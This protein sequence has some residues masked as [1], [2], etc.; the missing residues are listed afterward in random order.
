MPRLRRRGLA[1]MGPCRPD[2]P[3]CCCRGD[4]V[5][6][7]PHALPGGSGDDPAGSTVYAAGSPSIYG[8]GTGCGPRLPFVAHEGGGGGSS[9]GGDAACWLARRAVVPYALAAAATTACGTAPAPVPAPGYGCC[10]DD[11]DDSSICVMSVRNVPP[12]P[13]PRLGCA[14]AAARGACAATTASLS[15][16]RRADD[17]GPAVLRGGRCAVDVDRP[18]PVYGRS[19]AW[20]PSAGGCG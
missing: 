19:V 8:D 9:V 1:D 6:T 4:S 5:I 18:C 12:S 7:T 3:L 14:G 13:P 20:P 16:F 15:V 17:C 2:T 11:H 10:G